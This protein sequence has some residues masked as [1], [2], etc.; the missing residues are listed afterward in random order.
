MPALSSLPHSLSAGTCTTPSRPIRYSDYPIFK[1]SIRASTKKT[2]KANT[3]LGLGGA[4]ELR[5]PRAAA[6][7]PAFT[8][9][10][11]SNAVLQVWPEYGHQQQRQIPGHV[12]PAAIAE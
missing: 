12:H 7:E 2:A 8:Q 5:K 11:E 1:Q 10:G 9:D 6:E 3:S 4:A